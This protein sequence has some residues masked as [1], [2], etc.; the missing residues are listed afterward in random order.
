MTRARGMRSRSVIR[1]NG[2]ENQIEVPRSPHWD[3]DAIA[4]SRSMREPVDLLCAL[5]ASEAQSSPRFAHWIVR[6]ESFWEEERLTTR[7]Q[8]ILRWCAT[9]GLSMATLAFVVMFTRMLLRWT[10]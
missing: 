8:R 10:T 9:C 2:I 1:R 5:A 4:Q 6:G 7:Q 3:R